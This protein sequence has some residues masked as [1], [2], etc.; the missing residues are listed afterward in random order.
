MSFVRLVVFDITCNW[1]V[2]VDGSFRQPVFDLCDHSGRSR[3]QPSM[4]DSAL[5]AVLALRPT[6]MLKL[7]TD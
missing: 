6:S 4:A 1:M 7:K 5:R 3:K 2:M